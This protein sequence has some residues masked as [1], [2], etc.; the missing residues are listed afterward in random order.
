[1]NNPGVPLVEH[2]FAVE[3]HTVEVGVVLVLVVPVRGSLGGC[4]VW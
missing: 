3:V 1:M 2:T 4:F